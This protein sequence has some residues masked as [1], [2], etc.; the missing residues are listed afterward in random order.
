MKTKKR[1]GRSEHEQLRK[2]IINELAL[3]D[4]DLVDAG[5][6]M[7][8]PSQCYRIESNK[9]LYNANCPDSLKQKI[10]QILSRFPE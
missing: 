1:N 10:E 6:I 3:L 8:K 2:E 5:G 7:L 9:L 4:T